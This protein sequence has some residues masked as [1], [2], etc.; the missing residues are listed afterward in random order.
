MDILN[1]IQ[2]ILP[3]VKVTKNGHIE[4]T[5]N[6]T[7]ILAGVSRNMLNDKLIPVK[8]AE[9]LAEIGF[10]RDKLKETEYLNEAAVVVV[11]QYFALYARNPSEQAKMLLCAF[12]GVGVR[13]FFLDIKGHIEPASPV[14]KLAKMK[15]AYEAFGQMIAIYEYAGNKP[16]LENMVTHALTEANSGGLP[17][18]LTVEDILNRKGLEY[19]AEQKQAIGMYAATAFRNL[20]GQKPQQVR[21]SRRDQN[22]KLCHYMVAAYPIDFLPIVENAIELG[23]GS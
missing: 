15:E 7:C 9:M 8:L 22:G 16:G 10:D 4:I 17:G 21:K 3:E 1:V 18:L 5:K 11:I 14:T 6:A 12:G 2:G 19:T 23:F 20:T 13:S